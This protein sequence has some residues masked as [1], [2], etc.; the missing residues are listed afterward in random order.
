MTAKD[1]PTLIIMA[2]GM[3]SRYGG[4]K[5]VDKM[6]DAGEIIL[7]F[8]LYDAMMA[9]FTR[10]VFII[11]EEHRDIFREL[12]DERAGRFMDI[13]YAYQALDDIP[14]GVS[15]PEGREKAM[16]DISCSARCQRS[17]PRTVC[18]DKCR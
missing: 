11:R 12:V 17:D 18:R 5:Q 16:G 13:E 15:I 2:A 8:S 14:E 7:D 6:T 3:G 9:G 4:L 10:A 1:K